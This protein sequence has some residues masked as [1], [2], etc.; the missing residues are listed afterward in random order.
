MR[1]ES[2]GGQIGHPGVEV[3]ERALDRERCAHRALGVVLLRDRIAE[4]RHQ[5]VAELLGDMAAHCVTAAEA[6]SR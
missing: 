6:A 5:T 1:A 2:S 3:G 4:Q